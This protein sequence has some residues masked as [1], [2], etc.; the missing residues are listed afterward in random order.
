MSLKE[1]LNQVKERCDAATEGPWSDIKN[2]YGDQLQESLFCP[3]GDEIARVY[4]ENY[5]RSD[6]YEFIAHARQDVEVLLEMVKAMQPHIKHLKNTE[7]E[8]WVKIDESH[9][10][11]VKFKPF[12]ELAKKLE[13]LIPKGGE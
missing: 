4:D 8:K 1:Y 10:E 5:N 13:A 3:R 11:T 6:N 12:L 2:Q 7:F 9:S